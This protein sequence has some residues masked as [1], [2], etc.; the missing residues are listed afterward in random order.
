M[1][2]LL[3]IT[4]PPAALAVVPVYHR[5]VRTFLERYEYLLV[6]GA[7]ERIVAAKTRREY[8]ILKALMR[9]LTGSLIEDDFIDEEGQQRFDRILGN[10]AKLGLWPI[11]LGQ[12]KSLHLAV[13]RDISTIPQE[14]QRDLP[15]STNCT[16]TDPY[17]IL[18]GQITAI[19]PAY[20]VPLVPKDVAVDNLFN[21]VETTSQLAF[22]YLAERKILTRT[23]WEDLAITGGLSLASCSV[24]IGSILLPFLSQGTISWW[25]TGVSIVGTLYTLYKSGKLKTLRRQRK[26]LDEHFV[27]I[28]AELYQRGRINKEQTGA[29]LGFTKGLFDGIERRLRRSLA[30]EF[31][32]IDNDLAEDSGEWLGVWVEDSENE[33][34]YKRY[35][36]PDD[37]SK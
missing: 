2:K 21:G 7:K 15:Q 22:R 36:D 35:E 27:S 9:D 12:E 34:P 17:R 20:E 24:I 28:M 31:F 33:M 32:H 10:A 6:G 4:N 16:V 3:K 25:G 5:S 13:M 19:E 18:R 1:D 37:P 23:L 11:F 30:E 26:T 8:S 29:L 14:V